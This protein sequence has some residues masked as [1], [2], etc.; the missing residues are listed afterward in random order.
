MDIMSSAKKKEA[1]DRREKSRFPLRKELRYKLLQDTKVLETGTGETVNM[2]SCGVL[3]S[4]QKALE[5]GAFVELSISWPVLLDGTCAMRLV[6]FGRVLRSQGGVTACTIDKY[7][8]RT[9]ARAAV[10]PIS[11]NRGDAML[12]RWA[13]GV[14]KE[15]MRASMATA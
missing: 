4:I 15:T 10:T 3:F 6:A 14:R 8:F 11:V 7:E 9:Q 12:L 13:S 5:P 1:G 2:S